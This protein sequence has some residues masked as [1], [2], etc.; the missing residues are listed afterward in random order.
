VFSHDEAKQIMVASKELDKTID[1]F[2]KTFCK[3]L[4]EDASKGMN[5]K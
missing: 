5:D 2:F 4:I 1:R 3:A